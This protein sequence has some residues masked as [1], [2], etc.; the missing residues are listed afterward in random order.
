ML[1]GVCG[2]WHPAVAAG[3]HST[4]TEPLL[5][6]N[7]EFNLQ[8]PSLTLAQTRAWLQIL[9]EAAPQPEEPS[10]LM[11]FPGPNQLLALQQPLEE[12]RWPMRFGFRAGKRNFPLSWSVKITEAAQM[13]LPAPGLTR[14]VDEGQESIAWEDLMLFHKPFMYFPALCREQG[15]FRS[16]P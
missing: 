10:M 13:R 8:N 7:L 1:L 12:G 6:L 9:G 15:S 5:P 16:L 3:R 2:V 14:A 4:L 11:P